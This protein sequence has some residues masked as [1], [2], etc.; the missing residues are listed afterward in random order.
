MFTGTFYS[1]ATCDMMWCYMMWCYVMWCDV[2]LCDVMLCCDVMS[3]HDEEQNAFNYICLGK[4]INS[5]NL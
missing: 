5:F 1:K 4:L 2:M 3:Y